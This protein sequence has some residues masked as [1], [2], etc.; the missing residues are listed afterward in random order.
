RTPNPCVRCNPLIKFKVLLE[1]ANTINAYYISTGHYANVVYDERFDKYFIHKG[2]NLKKDQSYMLYRLKQ[3]VLSRLLLPL[4]TIE[5]KDRVRE[6]VKQ[7]DVSSADA[8]ESQEIC[9]V[10]DDNYIRIIEE[11]GYKSSPG[12]FIDLEG[13][14]IGRH[15]GIIHYTIGQRKG[16]GQAF[17]KPMFV[18]KIDPINNTVTLG[19][20]KDLFRKQVYAEDVIFTLNDSNTLPKEYKNVKIQ[21]KVRYTS[22]PA[23]AYLNQENGGIRVEFIEAQRAPTPGQSVVFYQDD[24]VVGGGIIRS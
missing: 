16:L 24:R 2:N 9:F 11:A 20:N 1:T 3:D 4:G 5:S 21:A 22:Q 7:Q 6:Y 15:K 19:D 23:D 13:N 10:K 12:D 18:V 14:V 17:G 8:E